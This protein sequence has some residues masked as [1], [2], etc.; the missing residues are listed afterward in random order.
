MTENDALAQQAA[1]MA[2]AV[3]YIKE[4]IAK[5]LHELENR[6]FRRLDSGEMTPQD[7][8]Q[9]LVEWRTLRKIARDATTRAQVGSSMEL[10]D[11]NI[12]Q[13]SGLMAR[14]LTA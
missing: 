5:A 4:H 13:P 2:P 14:K 9:V 7:A 12:L 3:P 10:T 11:E 1:R 6:A 8:F